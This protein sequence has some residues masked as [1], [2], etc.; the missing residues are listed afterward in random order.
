LVIDPSAAQVVSG[1]ALMLALGAELGA[2]VVA[3]PAPASRTG[4]TLTLSVTSGPRLLIDYHDPTGAGIQRTLDL[5]AESSVTPEII[6]IVAAHLIRNEAEELLKSINR[7]A[8]KRQ[9]ADAEVPPGTPEVKAVVAQPT[10]P[11]SV[12]ANRAMK[13][14][15]HVAIEGAIGPG[16][17]VS[18]VG[19]LSLSYTVTR[20]L[21]VGINNIDGFA[22]PLTDSIVPGTGGLAPPPTGGGG[23]INMAPFV[24]AFWFARPW[25]QLFWQLGVSLQLHW[26]GFADGVQLSVAPFIASGPRFWLGERVSLGL[27]VRLLEAPTGTYYIPGRSQPL[28]G[29]EF[30]GGLDLAVHF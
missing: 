29:L 14:R 24:E 18:F 13:H 12:V 25:L 2:H 23:V 15:F 5:S 26:G 21:S 3:A 17:G 4:G 22:P 9:S 27:D 7:R 16:D 1:E 20:F 28:S 10:A 30:N 11:V 19:G 8:D 6:A